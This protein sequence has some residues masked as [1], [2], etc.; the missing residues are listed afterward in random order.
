MKIQ[1]RRDLVMNHTL[2]DSTRISLMVGTVEHFYDVLEV[3]MPGVYELVADVH[4]LALAAADRGT[5]SL[6][7]KRRCP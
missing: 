6:K 1:M 5:E 3:E 2:R 7:S 4:D